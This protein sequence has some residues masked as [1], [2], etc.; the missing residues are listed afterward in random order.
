[1]FAFQ[2]GLTEKVQEASEIRLRKKRP[3][4]DF[5][6]ERDFFIS[7]RTKHP[8]FTRRKK[9]HRTIPIP[10]DLNHM[11]NDGR[12]VID[13]AGFGDVAPKRLQVP[14]RG[15]DSSRVFSFDPIPPISRFSAL[16]SHSDY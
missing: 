7:N 2:T 8:Y 12:S 1:M 3:S 15:G 13:L 14:C 4:L 10:R 9:L 11:A 5:L 6:K 16:M